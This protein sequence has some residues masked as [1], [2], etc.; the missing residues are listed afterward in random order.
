MKYEKAMMHF[1]RQCRQ[2]DFLDLL[3]TYDGTDIVVKEIDSYNYQCKFSSTEFEEEV[4]VLVKINDEKELVFAQCNCNDTEGV[5]ENSNPYCL[6][7]IGAYLSVLERFNPEANLIRY[8]EENADEIEWS[9]SIHDTYDF[10][11]GEFDEV[12][13]EEIQPLLD[14]ET[15]NSISM[16]HIFHGM[17]RDE[18]IDFLDNITTAFP[19]LKELLVQASM[20][21]SLIGEDSFDEFDE[22]DQIIKKKKDMLS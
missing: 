8:V 3:D 11:L 16:E 13:Q 21:A 7:I 20:L 12:Y 5:F 6:H 17:D 10:L 2:Y 19:P 9:E 18:I 15:L 22:I 1:L 14:E 4:E